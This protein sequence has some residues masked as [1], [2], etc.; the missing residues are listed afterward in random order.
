MLQLPPES[1]GYLL[2]LLGVD[3]ANFRESMLARQTQPFCGC[4][5]VLGIICTCAIII[6]IISDKE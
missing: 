1:G 4:G 3:G 5:N 6:I 2:Q